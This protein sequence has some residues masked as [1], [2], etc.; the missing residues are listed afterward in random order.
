MKEAKT[1]I[2]YTAP[3]CQ[4]CKKATQWLRM[5]GVE[6]IEKDYEQA[7]FK[8]EALPTIVIGDQILRGFSPRDLLNLIK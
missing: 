8:V 7:P 6:V 3:W 1:A 5:Q 2:I 4:A